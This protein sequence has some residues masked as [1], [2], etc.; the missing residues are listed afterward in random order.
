M[1]FLDFICLSF[2][3]TLFIDVK[4]LEISYN[5]NREYTTLNIFYL[6]LIDEFGF[7]GGN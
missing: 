4:I 5:M 6:K 7:D 3:E 2:D 1:P